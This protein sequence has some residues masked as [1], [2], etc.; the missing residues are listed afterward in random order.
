VHNTYHQFSI[1]SGSDLAGDMDSTL[2]SVFSN[3]LA[4]GITDF[5]R[6]RRTDKLVAKIWRETLFVEPVL[7]PIKKFTVLSYLLRV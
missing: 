4:G 7:I 3:D 1:L 2:S 5:L 6:R